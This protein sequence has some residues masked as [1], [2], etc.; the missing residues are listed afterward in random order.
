MH[1]IIQKFFIEKTN[2]T[3]VQFFR[4]IFVGGIATLADMGTLFA[5]YNTLS[6]HYLTATALGFL[7][8]IITNYLLSIAW[9]FQSTGNM[10]KEFTI[11]TIIGIGGLLWTEL[12]M[13][14]LVGKMKLAVMIAKIIAVFLVLMWNFGMRKKFVF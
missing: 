10:K 13:W 8:G 2:E 14:F 4:Y 3:F 12:I 7:A 5:L 6:I 1:N 11:F 9:V